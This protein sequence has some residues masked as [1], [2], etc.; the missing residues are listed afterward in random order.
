[1]NISGQENLYINFHNIFINFYNIFFI[2]ALFRAKKNWNFTKFLDFKFRFFFFVKLTINYFF[3]GNFFFLNWNIFRSFY[4]F[5]F[6]VA[7]EGGGETCISLS[8]KYPNIIIM[9]G[10]AIH[11]RSC[12]TAIMYLS[13]NETCS[14]IYIYIV[15]IYCE[16]NR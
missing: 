5:W 10:N 4:P 11:K 2:D 15:Y 7:F 13:W 12:V 14:Y 9:P 6:F 8:R 16:K 1:M 3:L